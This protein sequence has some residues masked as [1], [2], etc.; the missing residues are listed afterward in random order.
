MQDYETLN[1]DD[2][3]DICRERGIR[4]Y[5]NKNKAEIIDLIKRFERKKEREKLSIKKGIDST[6]EDLA[7]E[8]TQ[9]QCNK[10]E[11]R[12]YHVSFGSVSEKLSRL[13]N[14]KNRF[15]QE[16]KKELLFLSKNITY[17][18]GDF[19]I[20]NFIKIPTDIDVLLRQ[21]HLK[22]DQ[23]ILKENEKKEIEKIKLKYEEDIKE[24]KK[25]HYEKVNNPKYYIPS[26][27]FCPNCE[28]PIKW[29]DLKCSN[30]KIN[31]IFDNN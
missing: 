20:R 8:I 9:I 10:E 27:L 14:Q 16:Q 11:I 12:V 2:L 21:I 1:K 3:I 26:K 6:L 30:C 19:K 5:S 15:S 22:L 23:L 13:I 17:A 25:R 24:L 4:N 28:S 29:K 18:I 7:K 31:L